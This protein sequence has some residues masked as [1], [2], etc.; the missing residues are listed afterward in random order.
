M[1]DSDKPK[2]SVAITAMLVTFG[3]EATAPQITGY[4][5]GLRDLPLLAVEAAV[6]KALQTATRL[7]VPAELRELASGGSSSDRAI[8][9]WSD[10]QRACSVSYMADLDFGDWIINAV[11]R[12]LGGRWNFFERLNAGAESEKWLRVDF[13]KVYATYAQALPSG[14]ATRPLIG[15]ATHGEVAGRTHQPRLV[16]IESSDGRAQLLPERKKVAI[17]GPRV[18]NVPRVE[19]QRT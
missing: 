1:D 3:R 15:Q 14:E 10:V 11:I 9:A 5:L 13:L 16:I 7:P 2:F 18:G 19:F 6:A 8:A 12:N 4:W 17:E